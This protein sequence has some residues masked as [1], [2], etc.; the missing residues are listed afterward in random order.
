VLSKKGF[1]PNTGKRTEDEYFMLGD[2]SQSSADS[3]E[4]GK[5]KESYIRGKAVVR[6]WPPF[7]MGLVR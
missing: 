2:N 7:R 6:F 1:D 3:R 5:V 4:W